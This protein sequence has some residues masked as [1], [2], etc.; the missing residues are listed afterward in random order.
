[1]SDIDLEQAPVVTTPETAG[2]KLVNPRVIEISQE[3]YDALSVADP[4]SDEVEAFMQSNGL[5]FGQDVIV[6]INGSEQSTVLTTDKDDFFTRDREATV[7][8]NNDRL[9]NK[10]EQAA[11]NVDIELG[12]EAVEST[13]DFDDASTDAPEHAQV[14]TKQQMRDL[15]EAGRKASEAEVA[16]LQ[17]SKMSP[18][19]VAASERVIGVNREVNTPETP[20][21]SKDTNYDFL[22]DPNY[23]GGSAAEAAVI[24]EETPDE[25]SL[26]EMREHNN[27]LV[28]EQV[29][30]T[31][32]DIN[33]SR[34]L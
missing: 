10:S 30:G 7:A 24:H 3:Q 26:R 25:K 27:K 33:R 34:G 23:N 22:L 8:L 21:A 16:E 1:M 18:E 13:V 12:T 4:E 17:T 6:A 2:D 15:R 31:Q 9:A 14:F 20:D 32:S 29:I 11:E 19:E 28:Q 5:E